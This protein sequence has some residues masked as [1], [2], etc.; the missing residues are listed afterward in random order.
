MSGVTGIEL[1]PNYCVLVRGGRLG[2]HTDR[3][4]GRGDRALVVARRSARRSSSGSARPGRARTCRAA[5]ASSPGVTATR[6]RVVELGRGDGRGRASRHSS[7]QGSRS[8]PCSRPRRRSARVVRA[9]QVGAPAGTAVAAL[10]LN[11]HGARD[12]DCRGHRSHPLARRRV[13]ARDTV[14]GSA[15]GAFRAARSLSPRGAA[16]A[17]APARYRSGPAGTR[18]DGHVRRGVR[19]PAGPALD[20]DAPHRGDGHRGG[21]ARLGGA[22][23]SERRAGH[24]RRY[25]RVAP[26]GG[27]RRITGREPRARSRGQRLDVRDGATRPRNRRRSASG[28]ARVSRV[29]PRSPCSRSAPPGQWPR[30]PVRRPRVR[31]SPT[32]STTSWSRRIPLPAGTGAGE[33]ELRPEATTG[34]VD[35]VAPGAA[36]SV[37]GP[38]R[39]DSV[40]EPAMVPPG[41]RSVPGQTSLV[42]LPTAHRRWHHDRRVPPPRD[43]RG[44]RRR[45]RRP[46]RPARHR[47]HRAGR[48]R[49]ARGLGTRGLRGDQAQK[50]SRPRFV[51]D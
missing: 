34:R 47:P 49:L 50:T 29:W 42:G 7:R 37:P 39:G 10:S 33:P 6:R 51:R 13:V 12:R 44:A 21:N 2:S 27:G 14:R 5:R 15:W 43:C 17:A 35:A 31:S 36:T 41:R 24:A 1:G 48:R 3:V 25:G 46:R 19:Q 30:W 20:R 8:S 18:R 11:S 16:G 32:G 4:G 28:L 22:A 9:R 26:T 45:C 40:P 23:R 38:G